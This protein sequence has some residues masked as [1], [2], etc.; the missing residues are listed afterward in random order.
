M[1]SQCNC[2]IVGT[3]AELPRGEG[4]HPVGG[5]ADKIRLFMDLS[6]N[7]ALTPGEE[8]TLLDIDPSIWLRLRADPAH[9]DKIGGAKL[10]RRVNYAV[11]LLQRMIAAAAS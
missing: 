1:C 8:R 3:A 4:A 7:L 6:E 5:L 9:A 2:Q 10:S 11:F